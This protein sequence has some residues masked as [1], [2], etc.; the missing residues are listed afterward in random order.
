MIRPIDKNPAIEGAIALRDKFTTFWVEENDNT[1]RA[2]IGNVH[3]VGATKDAA[4]LSAAKRVASA[5]RV[6]VEND[7]TTLDRLERAIYDAESPA[8]ERDR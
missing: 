4:Y 3:G 8:T 5:L 6:Q 2:W 7:K 1:V